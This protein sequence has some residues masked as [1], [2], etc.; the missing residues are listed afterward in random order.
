MDHLIPLRAG[1][2]HSRGNL[3]ARCKGCH[4]RKTA[5]QDGGFGNE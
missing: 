5:S 2:T 1:G 4:S 3:I